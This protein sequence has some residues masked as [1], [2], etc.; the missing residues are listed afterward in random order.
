MKLEGRRILIIGSAS[1]DCDEARLAY[2]HNLV[3][4]LTVAL[5]LKRATFTVPF[6]KEPFLKGRTDGPS[7]IFDW[8]VAS[9]LADLLKSGKIQPNGPQGN[10][11][12][13]VASNKGGPPIIPNSRQNICEELQNSSAVQTE[14]LAPGWSAGALQRQILAR[15]SDIMIGISGGQGVE[16]A[17][18]EFSTRGK[19]IVP[20][21][22][23]L[24]CSSNDGSGGSS[25]LFRSALTRPDDFITVVPPASAAD[26]LN[27][28]RTSDGA[29]TERK[30]VEAIIKL[31]EALTP[32]QAFYVRLMNDKLPDYPKVEQFFRQTV[33]R[34]VEEMGFH[35]YQV[36]IED[37]TKPWINQ[38][39]FDSL[40]H[41]G[42]VIA[43]I[44]GLRPNCFAELGYGFGNG[45]K[46][47]LTADKDTESPF[48][49]A[50]I[51]T[52]IWNEKED[53]IEQLRRFKDHWKRNINR[54]RLVTP[55]QAR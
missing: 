23:S 44:T 34:A 25:K 12:A 9:T 10:L 46:V 36:N 54:P 5:A 35:P 8:S 7:I 48:D 33:D 1:E 15:I 11:I 6:G 52:F 49:I 50:P 17:A 18:V 40:H 13:T 21:D 38:A 45:Q 26:L 20:L 43:D 14:F 41:S 47:I 19:P 53:P 39:I 24:G 32:P 55:K 30:I 16:H 22:L 42:V 29:K 27:Q 28:T 31:L 37:V 4:E 3:Q 51:E 2:A